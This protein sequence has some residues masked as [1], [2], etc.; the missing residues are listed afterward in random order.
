VETLLA[1]EAS[2]DPIAHL[3]LNALEKSPT[4]ESWLTWLRSQIGRKCRNRTANGGV[5][6]AKVF[7]A[8]K[9]LPDDPE[10]ERP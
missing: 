3:V 6:L 8:V 9:A 7:D 1:L 4:F 10:E 5:F 2:N